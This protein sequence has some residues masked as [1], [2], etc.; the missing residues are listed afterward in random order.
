MLDDH[1]E[2]LD[3]MIHEDL[4]LFLGALRRVPAGQNLAVPASGL[5]RQVVASRCGRDFLAARAQDRH[6]LHQ[7]LPAHSK[8]L[9]QFPAAHRLAVALHP[10][11]NSPAPL[12]RRVQ[13]RFSIR[14]YL[15]LFI[16]YCLVRYLVSCQVV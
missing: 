12:L 9:R 8:A 5:R 14:Q 13:F 16:L 2:N 15:S 4:E 3:A 10:R 11:Q 7:T 6:V 1:V